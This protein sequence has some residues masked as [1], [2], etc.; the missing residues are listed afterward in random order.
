MHR[1]EAGMTLFLPASVCGTDC[2]LTR[3]IS[4]IQ[5]V[6]LALFKPSVRKNSATMPPCIVLCVESTDCFVQVLC[7]AIR[8]ELFVE[9]CVGLFCEKCA[10]KEVT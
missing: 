5:S 2:H 10:K 8:C 6:M 1:Q 9:K 3:V 7:C 4:S